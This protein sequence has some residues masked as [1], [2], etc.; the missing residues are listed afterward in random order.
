[1]NDQQDADTV[2]GSTKPYLI[3]AIYDWCL[4]EGQTPQIMVDVS[5]EGVAVPMS[6]ANEGKIVLNL[7]PNSVSQLEMGNEY[8]L[9][10]ARFSGRAENITVPVA[11]VLA[12][13]ARENGQ[14]IVFQPD[15][16]GVTPPPPRQER[17][18]PDDGN[19]PNTAAPPSGRAGTA[20]P[21]HLKVVK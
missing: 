2:H 10:S 11:A 16:S 3:R 13:Y 15:G 9:F 6:Y 5:I 18:S 7:H 1:V 4:D 8:L 12:V 20:G 14:G 21:S 17:K 19:D